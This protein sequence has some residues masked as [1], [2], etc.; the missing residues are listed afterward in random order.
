MD[1]IIEEYIGK[2]P[3]PYDYSVW[4]PKNCMGWA[5]GAPMPFLHDSNGGAL[6][7]DGDEFSATAAVYALNKKFGEG[8]TID[9]DDA[10]IA[11]RHMKAPFRAVFLGKV[12]MIED[13]NGK[14]SYF[15]WYEYDCAKAIMDIAK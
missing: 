9:N 6:A 7:F 5:I 10:P 13:A 2:H 3:L 12:W 1:K 15:G 14:H 4:T 8:G 11:Q